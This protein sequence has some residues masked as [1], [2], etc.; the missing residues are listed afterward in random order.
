MISGTRARLSAEIARQTRLAQD[1]A[2]GQADISSGKRLQAPSDDPVAAAR[3]A[4]IRQ[5]QADQKIWSAN[6]ETA[7]AVASQVDGTLTSVAS[8]IDRARE[9]MLSASSDTLNA[10]DRN[11]IAVELRGIAD[12]IHSYAAETDSRGYA[13]FPANDA[14]LIPIAP[15]VRV[16]A[17]G[18]RADIFGNV[19]TAGGPMDLEQ[20][21]RSAADA[22]EIADKTTRA[23]ATTGALATV[24]AAATHLSTVRGEHGVRAARIDSIRERLASSGLLL[25]EERTG[26]ESTDVTA[27]VA[28]INAQQLSLEAAQAVFARLNR[29]TL[30]DL[31]G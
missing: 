21:V 14:L 1:I 7:S 25:D 27:T 22:V 2:R 17:T 10:S 3:I 24:E 23:A 19:P 4:D 6:I 29:Q 12:D 5:T 26:L 20:L 16:P 11:I 28:R 8:A 18:S 13:L 15:G 9:L 31:L 30:F